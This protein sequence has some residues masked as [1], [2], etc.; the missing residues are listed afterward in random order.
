MSLFATLVPSP[1]GPLDVAVDADGALVRI[2]MLDD[3]ETPKI[4]AARGPAAT[5]RCAAVATQLDEYFRGKRREFD[6]LVRPRGTPFQL[7]A[8]RQLQ[9]IPYG[10]TISYVEEARR[11]GNPQ[12]ARA[13]G[14]ANGK[15]PIPIV[16]PCHRVVAADGTLGGFSAG[17]DRKR[18]LL[19]HEAAHLGRTTVS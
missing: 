1:L 6:L 13:V 18:W 8:W 10:A 3:G 5:A 15:N 16:I 2:D 4:S 19:D 14:G 12:A 11:L 17:L 7:S 9:R